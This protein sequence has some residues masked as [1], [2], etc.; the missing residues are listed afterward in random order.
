MRT[1]DGKKNFSMRIDDGK[2]SFSTTIDFP[3]KMA[4]YRKIWVEKRKNITLS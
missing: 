2:K 3:A 4:K 1:D